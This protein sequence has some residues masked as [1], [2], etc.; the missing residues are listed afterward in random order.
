[1]SGYKRTK[2]TIQFWDEGDADIRE[3]SGLEYDEAMRQY[4]ELMKEFDYT[5]FIKERS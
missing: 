4:A 2:N 1:M 5:K 3:I